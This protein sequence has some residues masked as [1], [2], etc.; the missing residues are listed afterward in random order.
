MTIPP[1]LSLWVGTS[2]EPWS[3]Q[4]AQ[5]REVEQADT[6]SFRVSRFILSSWSSPARITEALK[7]VAAEILP[8]VL[9]PSRMAVR[10]ALSGRTG[11]VESALAS[12]VV[13]DDGA[14]MAMSLP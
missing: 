3:V 4:L 1:L 12:E 10:M 11:A 8:M 2:Q 7:P 5:E 9:A 6:W 14:V 13:D